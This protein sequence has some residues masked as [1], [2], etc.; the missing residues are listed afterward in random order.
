MILLLVTKKV[1]EK[2]RKPFFISNAISKGDTHI[3]GLYLRVVRFYSEGKEKT[4]LLLN[5]R[6]PL[7]SRNS[8]NKLLSFFREK[9]ERYIN[10]MRDSRLL[11]KPD[12]ISEF[13]KNMSDIEK[14]N[15]EINDVYEDGSQDD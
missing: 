5:K 6:I 11:K 1:E 12:G 2:R 3:R 10:E 13:F 14:G 4:L 15:G 7:H 9:R 8:L